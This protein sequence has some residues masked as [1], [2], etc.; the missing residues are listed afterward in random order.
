MARANSERAARHDAVVH[1]EIHDGL[2]WL[3]DQ[4]ARI[5]YNADDCVCV[6]KLEQMLAQWIFVTEVLTR[7]G[8]ADDDLV[9]LVQP[10]VC[11]ETLTAQQ[12][13]SESRK[14]FWIGPAR[15][16]ILRLPERQRRMLGNQKTTV[17]PISRT[18]NCS[19]ESGGFYTG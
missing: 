2:R 12:G 16:R 5:P 6:A 9:G 19:A 8:F 15:D 13:N 17:P 18:R 14:I 11:I 7:E 3:G 1:R 4:E 10:L